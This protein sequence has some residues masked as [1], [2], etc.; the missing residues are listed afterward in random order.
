MRKVISLLLTTAFIS[1]L[2]CQA[3]SKL[4]P[5]TE[6]FF[7]ALGA[8]INKRLELDNMKPADAGKVRIIFDRST[9]LVLK[10]EQLNSGTNPQAQANI[11]DAAITETPLNTN[12]PGQRYLEEGMLFG[13]FNKPDGKTKTFSAV[14]KLHRI[15]LAVLDRYPNLFTSSELLSDKNTFCLKLHGRMAKQLLVARAPWIAFFRSNPSATREQI[16]QLADKN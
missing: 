6:G 2:P 8:R 4:D 13:D 5:D 15:P 1:L 12:F 3:T 9:G 11:I 10:I 7:T 14:V 16:I